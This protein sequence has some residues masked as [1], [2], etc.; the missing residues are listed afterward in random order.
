MPGLFTHEDFS[1]AQRLE[2]NIQRTIH[3]EGE[4]IPGLYDQVLGSGGGDNFHFIRGM[5]V[6]YKA[7]LAE[8]QRI[9][10]EMNNERAGRYETMAMN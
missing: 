10:H 5:I 1:F 8:M 9:E 7:V 3:G 6:A 4:E 2:R